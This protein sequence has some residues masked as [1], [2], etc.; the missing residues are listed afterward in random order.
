MSVAGENFINSAKTTITLILGNF[1]LYYIVD[2]IS[3]FIQF[4][5]LVVCVLIPSFIGGGIIWQS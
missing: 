5:A 4:Y 1:G 3:N 2:F